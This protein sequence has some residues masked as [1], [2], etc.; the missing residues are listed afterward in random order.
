MTFFLRKSEDMLYSGCQQIKPG[1]RSEGRGGKGAGE[2]IFALGGRH[3]PLKR[4]NSDKEIQ[5]NPS[6]FSWK[7]LAWAWAG[8]GG[9]CNIWGQALE[10][11]HN[12]C[13]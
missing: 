6:P 4:L 10:F 5:G 1:R 9:F 11:K 2:R 8:L 13:V 12:L 3:N 7:Y